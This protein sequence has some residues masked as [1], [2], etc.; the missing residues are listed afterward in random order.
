MKALFRK[1]PRTSWILILI[2]IFTLV[3]RLFFAYQTPYFSDSDAYLNERYIEGITQGSFL[4]KDDLTFSGHGLYTLPLFHVLFAGFKIILGGWTLKFIPEVIASLLVFLVFLI[5][6]RISDD[7]IASLLAAFSAGF[8]PFLFHTFFN[9]LSQNGLF[10]LLMF[11]MFYCFIRIK[12]KS[13]FNQF[14]VLAFL[15]P[16]INIYYFVVIFIF[17]IYLLLSRSESFEV[18]KLKKEVVVF[19]MLLGVLASFIVFKKPL[20]KLGFSVFW[21]NTPS[22]LLN[23]YF[24]SIDIVGTIF[25]LGLIPLLFG[26][27]GIYHGILKKKNENILLFSSICLAVLVLLLIRWVRFD[28]G[29]TVFGLALIIISSLGYGTFLDYMKL[30][31]VSEQAKTIKIVLFVLL[32]LGNVVPSI[33][34]VNSTL[35]STIGDSEYNGLLWLRNDADKVGEVLSSHEEGNYISSIAG[36]RTLIDDNF[37]Y[38]TNVNKRFDELM[39]I[40]TTQSEV[41]AKTLS[42]KYNIKYIYITKRTKELY[43]LDE[44]AFTKDE[45]CFRRAWQEGDT[46]IYK[47]RNC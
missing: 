38:G 18:A 27:Y 43:N 15:L 42:D 44:V 13:Y 1:I 32:I 34:V 3:F 40:Y 36:W 8:M 46:E 22:T 28:F 16:L 41:E 47:T 21:Q 14:I 30:T 26:V 10:I 4:F 45:R 24:S 17:L 19:T 12:E 11:Y 9:N 5:A 35:S 33:V 2:F 39:E 29:L 6:K 37:L 20:L 31:K 23:S 7:E 25:A